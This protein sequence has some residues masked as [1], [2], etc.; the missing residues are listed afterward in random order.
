[1]KRRKPPDL[2]AQTAWA[3]SAVPR[4][5]H[6]LGGLPRVSRIRESCG[7][8]RL[9][10]LTAPRP[11]GQVGTARR[12]DGPSMHPREADDRGWRSSIDH[13]CPEGSDVARK[14]K[15]RKSLVQFAAGLATSWMPKPLADFFATPLGAMLFVIGAPFLIATGVISVTWSNGLPSISFNR[16]RAV[17][18]GQQIGQRVGAEARQAAQQM[19]VA[20]PAMPQSPQAA[21]QVQPSYR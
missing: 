17:V 11:D 3:I 4:T 20:Q 6:L 15:K 9:R 12:T 19:Q 5:N 2:S 14:R 21:L 10:R 1:M 7:L 8:E 13:L 16:D 18:V